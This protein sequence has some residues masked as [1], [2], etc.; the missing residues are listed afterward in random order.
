MN[1]GFFFIAHWE[2]HNGSQVKSTEIINFVVK[3][4]NSRI[5]PIL[6]SEPSFC[7]G[8]AILKLRGHV[9]TAK[10][11]RECQSEAL[12]VLLPQKHII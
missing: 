11:T 9:Y 2:I 5:P 3:F 12:D 1:Y 10:V 4:T 6:L 8:G 7:V